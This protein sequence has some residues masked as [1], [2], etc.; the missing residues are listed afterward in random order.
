MKQRGHTN[1]GRGCPCPVPPPHHVTEVLYLIGSV[2]QIGAQGRAWPHGEYGAWLS[3]GGCPL[4]PPGCTPASALGVGDPAPPNLWGGGLP[5]YVG[6]A[7]KPSVT[8]PPHRVPGAS[9]DHEEPLES[10]GRRSVL[11]GGPGVTPNPC[12][13]AIAHA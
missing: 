9:E 13:C 7:D 2:W 6:G 1:A 3:G 12:A 10:Q 11:G 8:P 5:V 4:P